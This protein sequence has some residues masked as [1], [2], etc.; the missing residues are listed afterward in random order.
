MTFTESSRDPGSFARSAAKF[1]VISPGLMIL[2][3]AMTGLI[4]KS[5]HPV[6]MVLWGLISGGAVMLLVISGVVCALIALG[7]VGRFGREGLLVRGII[8]LVL[9]G[10]LLTMISL[11]MAKG[12]VR[13]RAQARE[14]QRAVRAAADDLRQ[15]VRQNFDAEQGVTNVDFAKIRAL[16][17]S[18]DRAAAHTHGDGPKM[19]KATRNYV[20]QLDLASRNLVGANSVLQ[21]GKVLQFTNAFDAD[22]FARRRR[23]VRNY[24][25]ASERIRAL[26]TNAP[27]FYRTE[28]QQ[29]GMA[30]SDIDKAVAS[31]LEESAAQKQLL[32]AVRDT[33]ARMTTAMLQLFDLLERNAADW[34]WKFGQLLFSNPQNVRSYNQLIYEIQSAA[35]DQVEAQRKLV[36]LK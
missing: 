21:V 2:L 11:S 15:S 24:Q 4:A 17:A 18:L 9:N 13:G 19:A 22:D 5:G 35:S 6:I 12:F 1:A 10:F 33:D 29:L 16:R 20:D 7:N 28:L 8:G 32:C 34:Q 25:A 36:S 14:S 26:L 27:T 23:L 3:A 30:P 31:M